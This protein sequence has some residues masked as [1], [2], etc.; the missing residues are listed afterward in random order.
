MPNTIKL[1]SAVSLTVFMIYTKM[2]IFVLKQDHLKDT[3]VGSKPR[4]GRRKPSVTQQQKRF[5][6]FAWEALGDEFGI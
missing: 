3:A 5:R 2:L 4:R 6:A 1:P